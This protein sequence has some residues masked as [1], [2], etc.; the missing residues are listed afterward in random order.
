YFIT[1]QTTQFNYKWRI[2][3]EL[4]IFGLIKHHLIEKNVILNIDI[5]FFFFENNKG[6]IYE[7]FSDILITDFSKW[8]TN[9]KKKFKLVIIA[10]SPECCGGW[11]QANKMFK[12]I[13]PNLALNI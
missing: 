4:T 1:H 8:F 2:F 6:E 13:F 12:K 5:D 10:L 7:A 3:N 9:N 11:T